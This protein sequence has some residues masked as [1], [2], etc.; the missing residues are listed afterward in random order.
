VVVVVVDV[1]A[2]VVVVVVVFVE[3]GVVVVVVVGVTVDVVVEFPVDLVGFAAA[4]GRIWSPTVS[5]HAAATARTST[6]STVF[7][8]SLSLAR[9]LCG[10]LIRAGNALTNA[11]TR[12]VREAHHEDFSIFAKK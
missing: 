8:F 10:V 7:I 12:K 3:F 4:A 5:A 9:S 2:A 11:N 6:N 1:F